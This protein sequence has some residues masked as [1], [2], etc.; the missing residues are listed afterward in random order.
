MNTD[1]RLAWGII[2]TGRIAKAFAKSIPTSRTGK[3]VAVGS[4]TQE[5]ADAFAKEFRTKAHGSYEAVLADPDVQAIYISTPHPM[6]IEW[7]IKAARAGKHILCEKPIGMNHSEAMMAAEAARNNGVFLM[8]AF[9]YRCHPQTAKIAEI[10]KSGLLG[11]VRLID[12]IFGFDA[13]AFDPKSRLFKQE[14]GGGA[15]LDVGC[16][17]MSM[18]RLVA[19]ASEGKA[20]A[21][22]VQV[23]GVG[24]LGKS[25]VDEFAQALLKFPSGI[26][27]QLAT[28]TR[29]NLGSSV[30]VTGSKAVLRIPSPWFCGYPAAKLEI[31]KKGKVKT[32]KVAAKAPLYSI[33]IDTVAKHIATGEAPCMSIDDTVGNM[34][35]LDRWRRDI[36]LVYDMEKERA[37][38]PRLPALRKSSA[39]PAPNFRMPVPGLDPKKTAS[40]M[41][42]GSI[43]EGAGSV[44]PH[45]FGLLDYFFEQGGNTFDTAYIYNAGEGERLLG[46]WMKQRGNRE[47]IVVIAKGAHTPFC[48]PKYLRSQF[49]E[50]LERMQIEYADIYMMHRDNPDV[51]A[52]EFVDVMNDEVRAGR[53]RIF[54]GSNWSLARID[55]ANAYAA[56]KGVQG[57][58][59]VSNQFSLARMINPVWAGCISASDAASKAWLKKTGMPLFAWSSQARGF[60]VRGS[61]GFTDD[62]E[63]AHCWYSDDNFERLKRVRKLAKQ[64]GTEPIHIAAA[65]VLHQP[66]SVFALIGPRQLSEIASSLKAFEVSLT[67]GE[68]AWLNLEADAQNG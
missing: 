16:Y 2:G 33:E 42:L 57:F 63:L 58:G 45:A 36:G 60:F 64:K 11:E 53:M 5:A 9:M 20:F 52:G 29:L 10:V 67:P 13:G 65:Y 54:G 68:M 8:E 43:F 28:A 47:E 37:R 14:L 19:G 49:L 38:R 30:T 50:S 61:R 46:E 56:K 31:V 41:V 39:R 18:A 32:I 44:A 24:H 59:A 22:P 3:L 12:A 40:R 34:L 62:A 7:T 15:I 4:R 26:Q 66:F 27:A 23:K 6:H 25:G 51:P 48:E 1:S 17:C 21:E 35:A 55:E